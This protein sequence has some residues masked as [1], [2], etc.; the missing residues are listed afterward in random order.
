MSQEPYDRMTL[1]LGA[2]HDVDLRRAAL[3]ALN[4]LGATRPLERRPFT[5]SIGHAEFGIAGETVLLAA[6]DEVGL[7]LSGPTI[8]V[9]HLARLTDEKLAR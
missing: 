9:G 3:W 7:S 5:G 1:V 6:D 8:L 2:E 4:K